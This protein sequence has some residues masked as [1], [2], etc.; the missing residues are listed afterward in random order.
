MGAFVDRTVRCIIRYDKKRTVAGA[1]PIGKSF[2]FETENGH[3]VSIGDTKIELP[4]RQNG[5][6]TWLV[7]SHL[8]TPEKFITSYLRNRY[9]VVFDSHVFCHDCNE[10]NMLGGEAAFST[11]EKESSALTDKELQGQI[12]DPLFELNLRFGNRDASRQEL[13]SRSRTWCVCNHLANED[14][15]R[16]HVFSG[17]LILFTE[18]NVTCPDCLDF[19]IKG[20]RRHDDDKLVSM[21]DDDFQCAIVDTLYSVNYELSMAQGFIGSL[22]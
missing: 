9:F 14:N 18:Y 5:V 17:N 16:R 6:K 12:F 13:N 20:S 1:R 15:F 7:C 10:K 11:M 3:F 19:V 8:D 2:L 21:P 4:Q 22:E